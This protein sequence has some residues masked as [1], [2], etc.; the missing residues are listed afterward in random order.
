MTG[1]AFCRKP[2]RVLRPLDLGKWV[3]GCSNRRGQDKSRNVRPVGRLGKTSNFNL[4]PNIAKVRHNLSF[5]PGRCSFS[6][7][8]TLRGAR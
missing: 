3:S 2:A 4:A 8:D 7:F 6:V 1:I 5:L